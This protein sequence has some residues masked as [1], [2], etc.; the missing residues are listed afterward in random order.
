MVLR[1][2]QGT[3]SFYKEIIKAMNKINT[4]TVQLALLVGFFG[5]IA[6]GL[7]CFSIEFSAEEAVATQAQEESIRHM[8]R[9]KTVAFERL[10]KEVYTWAE[11]EK[12]AFIGPVQWADNREDELILIQM[13]R[14]IG[15]WGIE[16][17][18]GEDNKILHTRGVT[19]NN[20]FITDIHI[21][22]GTVNY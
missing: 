21:D 20:G 12:G 22:H 15:K 5:L 8:K 14:I 13:D 9:K 18:Y 11:N 4:I 3:N 16:G 2:K 7:G 10:C 19:V 1:R 17:L 6:I